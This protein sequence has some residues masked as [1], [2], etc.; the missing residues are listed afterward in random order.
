MAFARTDEG[1]LRF[2]HDNGNWREW[3][4]AVWSQNNTEL[5]FN[6]GRE[7]AHSLA[8][9]EP[10][11]IRHDFGTRRA[12]CDEFMAGTTCCNPARLRATLGYFSS[13]TYRKKWLARKRADDA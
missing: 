4:G 1:R 3:T 11:G 6:F 7:L 12:A 10:A 9:K 2:D 8:V 5:P 13:M